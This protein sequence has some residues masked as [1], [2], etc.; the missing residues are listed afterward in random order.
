MIEGQ[1]VGVTIGV[2]A[3]LGGV[4]VY[5]GLANLSKDPGT[6]I[7]VLE[8]RSA[9]GCG[10]Q[11]S[12][13]L[14]DQTN[15]EQ[16][17]VFNQSAGNSATCQWGFPNDFVISA[18]GLA[19]KYWN[20]IVSDTVG[21]TPTSPLTIPPSGILL[22]D[23]I[24]QIGTAVQPT[25]QG[26]IADITNLYT[27][28]SRFDNQYWAEWFL[29]QAFYSNRNIAKRGQFKI[30]L[31]DSKKMLL[32]DGISPQLEGFAASY[33]H[34]EPHPKDQGIRDFKTN[35]ITYTV[36]LWFLPDLDV[37]IAVLVT[38]PP[39][40]TCFAH[41]VLES[42]RYNGEGSIGWHLFIEHLEPAVFTRIPREHRVRYQVGTKCQIAGLGFRF[43]K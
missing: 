28:R 18:K 25:R 33:G 35:T 20:P 43:P 27:L 41:I 6:S 1:T 17:V 21:G 12:Y 37:E 4:G 39:E 9:A 38:P 2:S 5:F 13:L 31:Y 3:D 24:L 30:Y 32:D 23:G 10:W 26:D 34:F 14:K 22:D 42:N 15:N 11:T 40:K 19:A 7:N 36:F 16:V 8:A 29:E